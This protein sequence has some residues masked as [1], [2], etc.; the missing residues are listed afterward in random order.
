[1]CEFAPIVFRVMAFEAIL[2]FAKARTA[3]DLRVRSMILQ[4]QSGGQSDEQQQENAV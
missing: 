1:M 2:L 4:R 3:L